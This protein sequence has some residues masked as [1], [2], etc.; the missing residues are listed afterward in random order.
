MNKQLFALLMLLKNSH[1]GTWNNLN[2]HCHNI[3]AWQVPVEIWGV[4]LQ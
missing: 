2:P 3:A 1:D 4:D